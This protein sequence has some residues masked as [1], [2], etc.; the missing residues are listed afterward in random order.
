[1]QSGWLTRYLERM[2]PGSDRVQIADDPLGMD[3][4]DSM[5]A[6]KPAQ[7]GFESDALRHCAYRRVH[8]RSASDASI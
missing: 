6:L 4:F 5:V 7:R 1:M 8:A 3:A 2:R